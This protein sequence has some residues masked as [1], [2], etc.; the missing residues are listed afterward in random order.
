MNLWTLLSFPTLG[1]FFSGLSYFRIQ[2]K[3]H[4]RAQAAK[5]REV[6]QQLYAAYESYSS[7]FFY[8]LPISIHDQLPKPDFPMSVELPAL[9]GHDKIDI[10]HTKTYE[11][12]GDLFALIMRIKLQRST[13]SLEGPNGVLTLPQGLTTISLLLT[14]A[15]YEIC[16]LENS[17][18]LARYKRSAQKTL[19]RLMT[20]PSAK[21]R[22]CDKTKAKGPHVTSQK[23]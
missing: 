10:Y 9:C 1:V 18:F 16:E 6:N 8:F 21:R 15:R 13:V 7:Y 2:K 5:A 11:I 3:A 23:V 20:P 12:F 14:Q 4:N 19:A 17:K 22:G